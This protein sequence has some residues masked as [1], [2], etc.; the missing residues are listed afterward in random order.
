ME[1]SGKYSS[2]YQYDTVSLKLVRI[3]LELNRS[4]D[5]GSGDTK[6]IYNENRGVGFTDQNLTEDDTVQNSDF[7]VD[8]TEVI[9]RNTPMSQTA[10][11]GSW[12][13]DMSSGSSGPHF[14]NP[15]I[16]DPNLPYGIETKHLSLLANQAIIDGKGYSLTTNDATAEALT[17]ALQAKVAQVVG[18]DSFTQV[19]DDDI[20]AKLTSQVTQIR[21]QSMQV[22]QDTIY[23]S[24]DEVNPLIEQLNNAINDGSLVPNQEVDDAFDSFQTA[25][26]KANGAMN[27]DAMT[28]ALNDLQT[29]HDALVT[30]VYNQEAQQ[31]EVY[32]EN[33]DKATD[34]IE[35]ASKASQAL[36]TI[37]AEY[38]N[39]EDAQSIEAYEDSMKGVEEI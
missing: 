31:A 1:G 3:R 11:E 19:T 8:N 18:R 24:L 13:V 23:S 14:G 35:A 27:T 25:L 36:D 5:S 37:P 34:G 12:V 10:S 38:E 7:S 2:Y 9:F 28:G 33:F 17:E 32:Q 21:E 26:G 39:T 15:V 16:N 20:L 6:V 4:T 22:E 30:A 29:A